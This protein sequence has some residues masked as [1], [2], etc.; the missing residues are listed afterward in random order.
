M[1]VR[2]FN[3]LRHVIPYSIWMEQTAFLLIK[4]K[5]INDMA[6]TNLAL[7]IRLCRWDFYMRTDL[8]MDPSAYQS[9]SIQHDFSGYYELPSC[10]PIEL[11][12]WVQHKVVPT[13]QTRVH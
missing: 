2:D 12:I 9:P 11:K 5:I 10:Q 13:T 8:L 7:E 1:Y 4:A 3:N 6:V